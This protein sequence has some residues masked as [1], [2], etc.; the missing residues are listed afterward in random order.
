M[1]ASS[2][3]FTDPF[4]SK[5]PYF[6]I[7]TKNQDVHRPHGCTNYCLTERF[8]FDAWNLIPVI[9]SLCVNNTVVL[10]LYNKDFIT[11]IS[12]VNFCLFPPV[13]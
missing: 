4:E 1:L 2:S 6:G 8:G 11:K 9:V 5:K 13:L 7:H 3:S 10:M 12:I